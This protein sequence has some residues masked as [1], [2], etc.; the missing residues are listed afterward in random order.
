MLHGARLQ[1]PHDLAERFPRRKSVLPIALVS[2][3][4]IGRLIFPT[5]SDK[6]NT[7]PNLRRAE[8]R[9]V[10]QIEAHG[11]PR[12]LQFAKNHVQRAPFDRLPVSLNSIGSRK[13]PA[14]IFY[15]QIRRFYF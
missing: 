10:V 8:I 14:Y 5:L 11:I 13:K 9:C 4:Q 15:Y 2:G 6:H 1:I 3:C 12:L 7:F